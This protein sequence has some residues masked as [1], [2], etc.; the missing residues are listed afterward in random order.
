[1]NVRENKQ[2]CGKGMP[3]LRSSRPAALP[4]GSWAS[5]CPT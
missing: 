2:D 5:F 3:D 4:Q 1:M